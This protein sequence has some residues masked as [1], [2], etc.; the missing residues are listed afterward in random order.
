MRSGH[1][2]A[3]WAVLLTATLYK[4]FFLNY[5]FPLKHTSISLTVFYPSPES[6]RRSRML[7]KKMLADETREKML[8][9][10]SPVGPHTQA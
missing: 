8:Y 1:S 7:R 2:T 3:H 10:A 5:T 4:H 9:T 6:Y